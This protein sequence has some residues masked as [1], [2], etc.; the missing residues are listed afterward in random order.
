MMKSIVILYNMT[1]YVG[2]IT[3]DFN[4]DYNPNHCERQCVRCKKIQKFNMFQEILY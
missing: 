1:I 2:K 4:T 3:M